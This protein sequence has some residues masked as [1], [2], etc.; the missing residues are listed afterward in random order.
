MNICFA[1]AKYM[2][3]YPGGGYAHMRQF[4]KNATEL[5]HRVWIWHGQQL[6]FSELVPKK[7]IAR[8][9]TLRKMDVIYYRIEWKA[10]IAAQW[11]LQPQ[12]TLVGNPLVVWEF[13]S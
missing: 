2:H 10:P 11:A 1:N 4:V 5:G 6:P 13:N 7:K 3:N 8:L 12:R 9:M